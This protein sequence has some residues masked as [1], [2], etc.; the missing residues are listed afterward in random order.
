M[1]TRTKRAGIAVLFASSI[2][3]SSLVSGINQETQPPPTTPAWQIATC[4]VSRVE[5]TGFADEIIDAEG[6]DEVLCPNANVVTRTVQATQCFDANRNTAQQACND[7]CVA[8]LYPLAG[9][10]GATCT[11]TVGAVNVAVDGECAVSGAPD[12]GRTSLVTCTRSG[13]VCDNLLLANSGGEQ[14]VCSSLPLADNNASASTCFDPTV[15]TASGACTNNYMD[16]KLGA[17]T[18]PTV[19]ITSVQANA[20]SCAPTPPAVVVAYGIPAETVATVQL[21]TSQVPL[22]SKGGSLA[23]T[24][25]GGGD[26][27]LITGL[28][29]M[30]I[31]LNDINVQGVAISGGSLTLRDPVA[32]SNNDGKLTIPAGTMTLQMNASVFGIPNYELLISPNSD[33]AVT[34]SG[35]TLSMAGQFSTIG[36]ALG[37][38]VIPATVTVSI[39]GSTASPNTSCAGLTP[40][41]QLLGFESSQSWHSSQVALSL[42][43]QNHTQGCFGLDV[44]GSG[45]RTLS[46]SAFQTPLPGMTSKLALDVFIPSGQPNQ[47]WLGAVQMYLSCPAE[48]FNNQYIG[49]DE[50]TGLPIGQFSTLSYP[51]PSP[52][53]SE[54]Q[55]SHND[56]FFTLAVNMNQ[57]ATAPVLDN[58]RF[59]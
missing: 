29:S 3:C 43:G 39:V 2:S 8:P 54:L 59:Q 47:F 36:A 12:R 53:F 10:N 38:K 31:A 14:F 50:L 57:A 9:E 46:S 18:Y 5:C 25:S 27:K 58:L 51:L 34:I 44:S 40:T 37:N 16:P 15:E 45:Y 55:G 6:D 11:S 35:T 7:Y 49:E 32:F 19:D 4:N 28:Q 41:Q 13:R 56:C 24:E 42:D 22:T 1:I 23:L 48:N 21:P 20:P 33:L 30:Q 17:L 52:I 26:V